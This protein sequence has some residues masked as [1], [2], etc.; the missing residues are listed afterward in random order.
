MKEIHLLTSLNTEEN[1]MHLCVAINEMRSVQKDRL[2]QK[3]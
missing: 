2:E 3:G 1:R